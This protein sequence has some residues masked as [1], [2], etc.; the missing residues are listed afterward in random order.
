MK[1]SKFFR[2][3]IEGDELNLEE[4]K[5]I[6]LPAKIYIKG[7]IYKT[8]NTQIEIEQKTNRWVFYSEQI[9]DKS[10]SK[11]LSTNLKILLNHLDE[12]KPFI[13]KFKTRAEIVLYADDKTDICLTKEH[14]KLLKKLETKFYISFC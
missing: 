3:I 11:F 2:F 4:I 1:V 5:S 12:L 7:E 10:I 8:I 14:I 13:S 6:N 9:D